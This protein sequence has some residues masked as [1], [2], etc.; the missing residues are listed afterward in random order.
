MSAHASTSFDP[1]KHVGVL[2]E[3]VTNV[4]STD[5]PG[6]SPD[7]DF[8]WNLAKFKKRLRVQV[9]RLSSRSIEF[10][11]IGVDA[12]VANALRR[13]LIAE[14]PA[15]AV[16]YV[17]VWN[18][19]SVMVDEVFSHRLGLLPLNI[20]PALM[21]MKAS[22]TDTATD[23]NTIVFKLQVSCTRNA[24]APKDSIDPK[25]LFINSEVLSS[26]LEWVPQG[27][28][29]DVFPQLPASTNP[30]IVLMKLRP[31]QEIDMELHAIKGVGKDH[32]KFSAVATASYRLLPQI[33][34]NPTKP[35]PPHLAEK[36]AG[37]FSPGVIRVDPRTKEISIDDE[38]LRTDSVSREVLRHPEFE[39]CVQLGRVRDHFI[40]HIESEGAYEPQRLLLEST[41]VMRQK[42]AD[43]KKAAEALMAVNVDDEDVSM[44]DA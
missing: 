36:F 20:D 25:Q 13:I 30:N 22:A 18:N 44:A 41:R 14:V 39:G 1:R 24:H 23:R 27:E 4:S 15:V 43:L 28:Q 32:A 12:S 31:G 5:F 37:C 40:F 7:E 16:E 2:A 42:I 6:Y 34:L 21:E 11:L 19:T 10:D 9:K 35:V 33:F 17:Y 38:K 3:R 26:H 29:A 8:S